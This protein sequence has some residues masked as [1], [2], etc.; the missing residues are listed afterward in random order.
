MVGLLVSE[1]F[2]LLNYAL[3]W[4]EDIEVQYPSKRTFDDLLYPKECR[5]AS[6]TYNAPT[7]AKIGYQT[8]FYNPGTMDEVGAE[9]IESGNIKYLQA[10]LGRLPIMI[11]SSKCNLQRN[12][13]KIK[14]NLNYSPQYIDDEKTLAECKEVFTKVNQT[15][16]SLTSNGEEF[17]EQGGYFIINGIEKVARMLTLQRRNFPLLQTRPHYSQSGP[18]F[19]Q[20]LCSI[21]CVRRDETGHTNA[22][23]YL[24]N[25]DV[26]M[27]F[28]YRKQN[29]FIPAIL[30]LRA[31]RQT[32]DREIYQLITQGDHDNTFLT[33]R[34]EVM[35]RSWREG[36]KNQSINTQEECL[37]HIGSIFRHNLDLPSRVSDLEAG[38][39]LLDKC[40][41]SHLDDDFDKFHLLIYMI[42]KLY[43]LASGETVQDNADSPVNQELLLPGHLLLMVYKEKLQD[44][45]YSVRGIVMK[46]IRL[47]KANADIHNETYLKSVINK[48]IDLGSK[49]EFFLA[50][51]NLVSSSG[52]DLRQTS[53]FSVVAERLNYFRFISHFRSVH[54]GQFFTQLRTTD[55]RKLQP[56]SWGFFCPVHTPDGAPCG[57]LNHLAATCTVS[58]G[59]NVNDYSSNILPILLKLGMSSIVNSTMSSES[60]Y[61][62]LDG[63]VIGFI[64]NNQAEQV[65]ESLRYLKILSGYADPNCDIYKLGL[66]EY[67]EKSK[68]IISDYIPWDLEI[69]LVPR[70]NQYPTLYL[71][72]AITRMMRPVMNLVHNKIEI[73]GTFEQQYLS[74]D[75][76]SYNSHAIALTGDNPQYISTQGNYIYSHKEI[77]PTFIFSEV[78]SLTPF[79]EYNQSPRNM[80]QCQMCKQ[81]M[82]TPLHS[83]TERADNKLYRIL[84]PQFPIV[85]TD[86]QDRFQFDSYAHGTNAVVAVI[87]YTG[88]DMEDAMIINK[89]SY[90]RGFKHGYIYKSEV[91]D[92]SDQGSAKEGLLVYFNNITPTGEKHEESLDYDGL[93]FSGHTLKKGDPMYCV[94]DETTKK[95]VTHRYSGSEKTTVEDVVL[96]GIGKDS[97]NDSLRASQKAVFKLRYKRF[98]TRGDKFSSRHGQKGVLSQ[99]WPEV[100][101]PFSTSGM[102]PDIIINPNAF[103]SRM[104][105]GMLIESM[106]AKAGSLNGHTQDSTPFNFD[107]KNTAVDYFGDQL[108]K[109]GF[110]YY[111]NEV[112]YSGITGEQFHTDIFFGIVYYQRLRHMVGDKYQVRSTGPRN[113]L[114]RQPVKGRKRGGGIRVGEMERDSLLAHG[115][116]YM[117]KDRLFNC[118]DKSICYACKKCGS[119]IS[120]V[121]QP[122][123]PTDG[124]E[125]SMFVDN[126]FEGMVTNPTSDA[127]MCLL[128]KDP[129]SIVTLEIPF[130]FRYLLSELTAMNI[131]VTLDVK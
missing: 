43:A 60:I 18:N 54:R 63:K 96:V 59:C 27:R 58:T 115:V 95:F 33:D 81:T 9:P 49:L 125:T 123:A 108:L 1:C 111:G 124:E 69:C 102:T 64:K 5:L 109:N 78:A 129:K 80:Y 119:I 15:R 118:S 21:R 114:T 6:I 117:L 71:F 31:W 77:D 116:T 82:G 101:M 122:T 104:T 41:L 72:S 42:K 106:A 66:L 50:T 89:S 55:V 83:Y 70:R 17:T 127:W 51:G 53:G 91:I 22:L 99:L 52:L 61:V 24:L 45:L 47:G 29:F 97:Q 39:I 121:R 2:C 12:I 105:I 46:E 11:R 98:P 128:C 37:S 14:G 13:N 76:S 56:E 79:S 10:S 40:V 84:T 44:W 131:R 100:D 68:P 92:V 113:I 36:E 74:I 20:H 8:E 19:S 130:V 90:E 62:V 67:K 107:E 112:L 126:I 28:R 65:V 88:Y 16:K 110:N 35:L 120:P 32:T 4:I 30:L 23:H 48:T 75:C 7:L 57:L 93:P 85:K 3:V 86:K 34:V 87:S 38:K 73:I 94:Y 25:G 26:T 103:P